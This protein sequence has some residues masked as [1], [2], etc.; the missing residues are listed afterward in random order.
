MT[1]ALLPILLFSG[2]LSTFSCSKATPISDLPC[3]LTLY[4]PSLRQAHFFSLAITN[5]NKYVCIE[6]P[7]RDFSTM[8]AMSSIPTD[9]V[10]FLEDV[11]ENNAVKNTTHTVFK[12]LVRRN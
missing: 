8:L 7:L 11:F 12:A 10:F 2:F 9:C 5:Y 4:I 6:T 1:I 3:S